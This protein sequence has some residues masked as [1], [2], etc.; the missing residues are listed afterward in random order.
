MM[1]CT[2]KGLNEG[3]HTIRSNFLAVNACIQSCRC[4][5]AVCGPAPWAHLGDGCLDLI[6][7]RKF[8]AFRFVA[9]NNHSTYVDDSVEKHLNDRQN[10]V[11]DCGKAHNDELKST[12]DDS[13]T[14]PLPHHSHLSIKNSSCTHKSS[15]Q[16][17]KKTSLWCCDGELIQKSNIICL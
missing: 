9:Y 8:R 6:L 3:W 15:S 17:Y 5:R 12:T 13:F 1:K 4:A 11:I 14:Q 10:V 7:V 16:S 2:P